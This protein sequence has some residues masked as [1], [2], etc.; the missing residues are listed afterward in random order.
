M[1]KT[2][3]L[4]I[5]N[6]ETISKEVSKMTRRQT[7]KRRTD[8]NAIQLPPGYKIEVFMEGLTTPINTIFI[9]EGIMLIADAGI[10]TGNGKVL[11]VTADGIK[12]IAEGFQPPLT[13]ITYH[14]GEIYVAHR[15][16]ITVVQKDGKKKD[17]LAGLPS[18]GDHHNNR[19]AFGADG[20]MYFGQ[21]TATNSG[22]VGKD[23]NRWLKAHPFFHDY[24]G[25]FI[26]L[27]GQ[28]FQTKNYLIDN[29]KEKAITGAFSPFNVPTYEGEYMKGITRAN[30]S[31][32]RANLDGSDLEL[33]AWGLRNPFRLQFDR[34]N[35]LYCANHGMDVRGSRPVADAPDEFYLIKYGY[36]YGWPDYAAGIPV[37]NPRFKAEGKNQ[38]SFLLDVHPMKPPKPVVS[39]P[40]HS[41]AM[42]FD[43]NDNPKFGQ[44]NEVYMAEFGSEF[45][46]TGGQSMPNIG[47][48]VSIINLDK[49]TINTFAINKTRKPASETGDG[50]FE[51]PI[52]I[53]FGSN[54]EMYVTDFGILNQLP[55]TGVIWKI[56]RE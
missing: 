30:G 36:W 22:V 52:D 16:F 55:N 54:N 14:N 29:Q 10:T 19:V 1:I 20:K 2:R 49:R 35:Q 28:N 47:H 26:K 11:Q 32:L 42:G 25:S 40:P 9:D 27:A 34:H 31:I 24:P 39:F 6:I 33:V 15:G 12:V 56:T 5:Y 46:R 50:G 18:F 17:I 4:G 38:P 21:G 45:P 23:N 44:I 43:F 8:P 7:G 13:G 48:R 51:R 3:P 41:A 37:T 53:T